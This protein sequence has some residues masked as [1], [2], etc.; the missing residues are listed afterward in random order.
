MA[1]DTLN[2]LDDGGLFPRLQQRY[3]LR[4]NPLEM[5]A[6]F[7]SGAGRQQALESLRHLC[8]FG[9]LALVVCGEQGTGKTRM[10]AE[11]VRHETSRLDIHRIPSAALSSAQAL[12]RDLKKLARS[13]IADDAGIK[14]AVQS[15]FRWSES[16][17]QRGRRQVL[18]VDDAD[19]GAPDVLQLLLAG[20]LAADR[21]M[22]AIPVFAGEPSLYSV[23]S[24]WVDASHLHHMFLPL[25]SPEEIRAYLQPRVERA[26]GPEKQLLSSARVKKIHALSEGRFGGVKRVAPGVWLDMV[27][28]RAG[29]P[30]ARRLPSFS[31]AVAFRTLRWPALALVLLGG[32]FWFVSQQYNDA[33]RESEKPPKA[34]PVRK[35]ITVGPDNPQVADGQSGKVERTA[36]PLPGAELQPELEP[37]PDVQSQPEPLSPPNEQP[38]TVPPEPEPEP[39]PQFEPANPEAFVP[40]SQLRRENGW[41]LQLVAGQLEQTVLNV[42]ERAPANSNLRYTLGERQGGPWFM[43]V[44]GRYE[45]KD[46]ARAAGANLPGALRIDNPWVRSFDSF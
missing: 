32:S 18:L 43:L 1:R 10:L 24:E 12:I 42:L 16:R 13:A 39:E 41:T 44:Y 9:D 40:I 8:G 34:E 37:G 22:A 28:G 38:D 4:E 27:S 29:P 15:Y 33:I 25:L 6:P 20:F 7:F 21:S 31:G 36:E 11:L 5:E 17:A 35:S 26:G 23:I 19:Q 14:E 45:S 30:A 2:S 3:G 46:R